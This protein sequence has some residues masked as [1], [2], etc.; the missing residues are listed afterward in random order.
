MLFKKVSIACSKNSPPRWLRSSIVYMSN[1]SNSLTTTVSK[2]IWV[3]T[4]YLFL[5]T[6]VRTIKQIAAWDREH[7]AP[8]SIFTSCCYL[9]DSEDNLISESIT[10]TSLIT[11]VSKVIENVREKHQYLPL[12]INVFACSDECTA[13]VQSIYVFT[14][15]STFDSEFNLVLPRKTPWQKSH[16]RYWWNFK[17]FGL[18]DA[19]RMC[20]WHS[21][22]V[23]RICRKIG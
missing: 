21:Q 18:S 1:M 3:G 12:R 5:L 2:T 14:L 9:R 6:R 11:C 19:R 23:C 8:F 4:T 17:K 20:N 15:L 13:Q 10:I 16:R 7:L 22:T